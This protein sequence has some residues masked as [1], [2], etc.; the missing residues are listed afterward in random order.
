MA[1]RC[2]FLFF[3]FI[4][5]FRFAARQVLAEGQQ[6]IF[7]GLEQVRHFWRSSVNFA[8]CSLSRASE[9]SAA[10]SQCVRRFFVGGFF[11]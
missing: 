8:S 9:R 11:S 3:E 5:E 2:D 7:L 4:V 10:S 6:L 1:L